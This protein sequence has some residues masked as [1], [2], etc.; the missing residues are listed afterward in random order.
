MKKVIIKYG[1][2]EFQCTVDFEGARYGRASVNVKEVIH[3]NRRF[4]RT[5]FFGE[6]YGFRITDY[7]TIME[8]VEQKV[9]DHIADQAYD[10]EIIQKIREFENTK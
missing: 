6:T 4:F 3:P 9:A 7:E 8:A 5:E 1:R 10:N 2:R